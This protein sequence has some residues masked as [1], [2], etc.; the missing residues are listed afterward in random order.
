[1]SWRTNVWYSLVARAGAASLA[2][3]PWT[4][5]MKQTCASWTLAGGVPLPVVQR[6]FGYESISTTVTCTSILTWKMPRRSPMSLGVGLG[7]PHRPLASSANAVAAHGSSD[8]AARKRNPAV[9]E[10][11]QPL[12][13]TRRVILGG[14]LSRTACGHDAVREPVTTRHVNVDMVNAEHSSRMPSALPYD[15]A[16]YGP[17]PK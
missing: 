9:G 17:T 14:R 6:Y 15:D 5:D 12:I 4:H 16:R 2:K 3:Q 1:M 13:V 11:V 8:R 7:Q 10:T